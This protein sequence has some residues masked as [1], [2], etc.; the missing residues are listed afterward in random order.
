VRDQGLLRSLYDPNE[1]QDVLAAIGTVPPRAEGTGRVRSVAEP[2]IKILEKLVR[3]YR[4]T[5]PVCTADEHLRQ[6]FRDERWNDLERLLIKHG[7]V[8]RET[9]ATGGQP[10]IFLRRQVLPDH[11][12]AGLD[13]L[14]AVPPQVGAF[15]D[16]LERVHPKR[17]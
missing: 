8:S 17:V 13:R 3:A 10:K 2:Y 16:E 14:N 11:I 7:V 5:N 1:I 6:I 4:R 12:M 9:R 15:W